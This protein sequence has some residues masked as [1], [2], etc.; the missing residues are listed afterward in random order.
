M[1]NTKQAIKRIRQNNKVH[2][3]QKGQAT[4]V[5]TAVNKV[6]AAVANNAENTQ[7][8]FVEASR[9][10]D[11]AVSKGLIHKNKAARKKSRLSKLVNNN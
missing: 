6:E 3:L 7:E 9:S 2:E 11:K 1:A 10:L 5:R 8:L 4:A